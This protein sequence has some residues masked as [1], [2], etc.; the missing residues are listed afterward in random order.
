[1]SQPQ[2][3]TFRV[4]DQVLTAAQ[5][6][7]AAPKKSKA[8]SFG[9]TRVDSRQNAKLSLGFVAEGFSPAH[10]AKAEADHKKAR[11]EAIDFNRR[12][13]GSDPTRMKIPPEWDLAAYLVKAKP[14]KARPKPYES[15][16]AAEQCAAMLRKQGWVNVAV[17]EELRA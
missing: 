1:M 12:L 15:E 3:L 5:L 14:T 13:K 8:P 4:G 17:R 2:P 6:E 7:A 10:L 11:Q 16:D 9:L